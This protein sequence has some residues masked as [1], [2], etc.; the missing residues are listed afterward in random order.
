MTIKEYE[1]LGQLSTACD[2]HWDELTEW[3]K[4]FMEDILERFREWGIKTKIS[5][6]QWEIITRIS[7]KI[8]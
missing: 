4:K 3:E 8:I 6:K 2:L 5:P 7:E 1:W